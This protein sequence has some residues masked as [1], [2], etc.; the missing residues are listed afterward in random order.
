MNSRRRVNST[1]MPLP[2]RTMKA[3]IAILLLLIALA[4]VIAKPRIEYRD[5][6]QKG[7]EYRPLENL[8]LAATEVA[9]QGTVEIAVAGGSYP[10]SKYSVRVIIN[11]E[12]FCAIT[13]Q[14]YERVAANFDIL[15]ADDKNKTIR[16]SYLR[17]V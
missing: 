10:A 16:D 7:P 3:I 6:S 5:F 13:V 11:F 9:Y 12:T 1:V 15:V 2:N 17:T 8:R 4:P 14:G